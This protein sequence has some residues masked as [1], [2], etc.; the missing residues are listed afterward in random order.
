MASY[1]HANELTLQRRE[2][3]RLRRGLREIREMVDP[4]LDKDDNTVRLLHDCFCIRCL[5]TRALK[6]TK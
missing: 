2:I 3:R 1:R 4:H 5:A 6:G